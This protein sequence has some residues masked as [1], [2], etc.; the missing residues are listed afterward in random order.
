MHARVL[1]IA[2][3]FD[4]MITE[5]RYRSALSLVQA[6]NDE[7]TRMSGTQFD[8]RSYQTFIQAALSCDSALQIDVE[9]RWKTFGFEDHVADLLPPQQ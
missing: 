4:A 7:L 5:Q 1:S 6:L 3:A 2:D 8:R 9:E